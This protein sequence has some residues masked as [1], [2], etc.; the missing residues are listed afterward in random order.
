MLI[1]VSI[2]VVNSI[3]VFSDPQNKYTITII[4]LN[5]TAA[6]ASI[7]GII[8]VYRHGLHGAHSK[9]YLFLT[10][11]LISW[12]AADLTLAY[13]YF[14]LGIEEQLLVS[15]TD[16]LWF[17]GY[18][19]LAAHLFTVLMIVRHKINLLTIILA[20]IFPLLFVIYNTSIIIS[21]RHYGTGDY[22]A[23]L[24]T[25]AYPILDLVLIIPSLL[26][27]ISL[28]RDHL[29]SIPWFLASFSLLI[30]AIADEGYLVNFVNGNLKNLSFWDLFYIADFII[31]AGAL[32]W[33]NKFHI[34][35][36]QKGMSVLE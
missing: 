21:S 25:L 22:G 14:A 31:I 26:I 3:V 6:I 33:Y 27:L 23:L 29:Q 30:N 10:L 1:V 8:A 34:S 35:H 7:L 36:M 2:I 11:G 4:A 5:T 9:S 13:Y 12:F 16:V 19:F 24:V 28:L 18:V 17:T 32:I 15:V 20:S